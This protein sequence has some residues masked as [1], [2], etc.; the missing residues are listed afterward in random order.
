[1]NF[2]PKINLKGRNDLRKER[3]LSRGKTFPYLGL[4]IFSGQQ[5]SGKTL[6][7]MHCINGIL[8]EYPDCMLVSNI[9]I[10]GRNA[11]PYSGIKDFEKYHNG[12]QG[13]IYLIDEIHT[14]FSSLESQNMPVSTLTVWSQNRKN[15]RLILGTS[16]RFTRAAKGLREQTTWHYDCKREI[17]I[18]LLGWTLFPY[19][20]YD[21]QEY[22]D[23]GEYEGEEPKLQFYFPQKGVFRSYNTKEVVK[24]NDDS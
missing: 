22:N 21:G 17:I 6:L 13:I 14:L 1:M 9:N 12:D 16:Q 24:R 10:Y 15:R 2:S 7:A 23:D 3:Q 8:D 4:W 20:I 19:R 18:P 5:G 11:I